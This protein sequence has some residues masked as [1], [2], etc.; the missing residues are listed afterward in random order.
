MLANE[1]IR[2]PYQFVS[3][4]RDP[5]VPRWG[6]AHKDFVR[7]AY[8]RIIPVQGPTQEIPV[9][10]S[11]VTL[12]PRVRD[13][14]G[15]PVA[16]ISG[17]RHPHTLEISEYMAE[18]AAEWLRASGAVK[19]WLR[20]AGRGVSGGQHQA[21]TCRMGKDPKT[22]VVDP[23]CRIHDTDNVYVVDASVHVTN[24]GFNPVLTIMALA[25]RTGAHLAR[26]G[27]RA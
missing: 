10:D 15:I 12:D 14:F 3:G 27:R 2:L 22:S 20:R 18:R 1:F 13:R 11:R 8:R 23:W 9:F 26:E 5:D 6:R 24:G 16:R 21:G 25:Y 4:I 19:V 17:Y 7:R